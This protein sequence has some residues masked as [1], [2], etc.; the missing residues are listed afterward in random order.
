LQIDAVWGD[1]EG[2]MA[3]VHAQ[4]SAAVKDI[5]AA[6][7]LGEQVA[8]SLKAGVARAGGTLLIDS[9]PDES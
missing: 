9:K 2:R 1:P 7:A 8:A 4:A 3:L 5:D 6:T